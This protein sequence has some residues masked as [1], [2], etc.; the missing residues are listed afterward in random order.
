MDNDNKKYG[1]YFANLAEYNNGKMVG[2]WLYPLEYKTFEDFVTAIKKV[3]RNADEIAVHD[4]DNFVD[5]GEY[6]SHESIYNLAHA[7]D[8]SHLDNEIIIKYFN[9]FYSN[10]YEE[11]IDEIKNIEDNFINEYDSFKEYA[12]EFA[13]EEIYC[14]IPK[15]A[16]Q[17]VFNHFD[18]DSYARDL[19]CDYYVIDLDNNKVAI[20][21]A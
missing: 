14:Q 12:D 18:Y 21:H 5:M 7:L 17:F 19:E 8:N 9:D 15:E 2:D 13:D 11:L 1:V 20:F 3:T 6:P 10:D 4:Y 16:Q